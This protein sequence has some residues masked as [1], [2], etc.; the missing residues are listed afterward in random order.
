MMMDRRLKQGSALGLGNSIFRLAPVALVALAA[1]ACNPAPTAQTANKPA[2]NTQTAD[3]DSGKTV[4]NP[5][6][7]HPLSDNPDPDEY[8]EFLA[9]PEELVSVPTNEIA[10]SIRLNATATAV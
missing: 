5:P 6:G 7:G 1:A 9:R 3:A 10:K 2:A 4:L 8:G